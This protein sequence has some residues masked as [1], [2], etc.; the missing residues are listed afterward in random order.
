MDNSPTPPQV[1]GGGGG[2]GGLSL[3]GALLPGSYFQ[4]AENLDTLN[5]AWLYVSI[6]YWVKL[7]KGMGKGIFGSFVLK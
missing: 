7:W 5:H 2:G 1:G 3:I 4:A 6:E